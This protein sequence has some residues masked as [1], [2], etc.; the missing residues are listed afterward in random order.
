MSL[1][2]AFNAHFIEFLEDVSRVFPTDTHI[3]S[4]IVFIRNIKKINP[5]LLLKSWHD[6]VVKPYGENIQTGNIDFFITK[7][8]TDDLGTSTQYNSK[9]MLDII[10][11]IKKK[12][13]T[14]NETDRNNVVKYLQNLT[15]LCNLYYNDSQ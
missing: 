6:Y 3:R 2:K 11:D 4:T 12:T 1:V 5:S 7:D 13:A 9:K 15:K 10:S 8:Y 14:M